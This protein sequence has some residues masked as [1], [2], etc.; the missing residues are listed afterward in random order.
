S[1]I[2]IDSPCLYVLK[3][4]NV[5]IDNLDDFTQDVSATV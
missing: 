2:F 3:I 1:H 5:V 4:C